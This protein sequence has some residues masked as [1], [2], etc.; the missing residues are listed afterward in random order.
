[1]RIT[2]G[3]TFTFP[4]ARHGERDGH[5]AHGGNGL[6]DEKIEKILEDN[7]KV[8]YAAPVRFCGKETVTRH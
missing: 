6:P 4:G 2:V 1:M 7:M 5:P 3:L 8:T